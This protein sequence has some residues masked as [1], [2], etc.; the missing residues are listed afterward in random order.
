VLQGANTS[1]IEGGLIHGSSGT[2]TLG[3]GTGTPATPSVITIQGNHG[4]QTDTFNLGYDTSTI[5][6]GTVKVRYAN[7][8]GNSGAFF[9]VGWSDGGA[10]NAALTAFHETSGGT[11]FDPLP[12]SGGVAIVGPTSGTVAIFNGTA[13]LATAGTAVVAVSSGSQTIQSVRCCSSLASGVSPRL[14][15]PRQPVS[16]SHRLFGIYAT[17]QTKLLVIGRSC[18]ANKNAMLVIDTR[19]P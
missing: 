3:D 2:L 16:I 12:G 9:N 4:T 14:D 1:G 18:A 8:S 15:L 11:D 5:E 13:T 7:T 6:N 10:D 17:N 19:R